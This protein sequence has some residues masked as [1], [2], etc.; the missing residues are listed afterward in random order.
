MIPLLNTAQR[1][2]V[3]V[4]MCLPVQ[5]F[6][7]LW[8]GRLLKKKFLVHCRLLFLSQLPFLFSTGELLTEQTISK[9]L[10]DDLAVDR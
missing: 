3:S 2:S 5:N 8:P 4:A 1:L 6:M 10:D 7:F 9:S